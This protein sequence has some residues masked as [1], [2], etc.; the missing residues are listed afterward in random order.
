MIFE[1]DLSKFTSVYEVEWQQPQPDC[2]YIA[3]FGAALAAEIDAGILY[4]LLRLVKKEQLLES[5][6]PSK[7]YFE[8][9]GT[10]WFF[11]SQKAAVWFQLSQR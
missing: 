1:P 3:D 11:E 7:F 2:D 6:D 4:Q 5:L 10:R 9:E 8:D